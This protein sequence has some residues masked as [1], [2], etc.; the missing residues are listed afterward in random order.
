MHKLATPKWPLLTPLEPHLSLIILQKPMIRE[1]SSQKVSPLLETKRLTCSMISRNTSFF[2]CFI[3][4]G[5][6]PNAP[7]TCTVAFLACCL[8]FSYERTRFLS[9]FLC[10]CCEPTQVKI[11]IQYQSSKQTKLETQHKLALKVL[12]A[13]SAN[14]VCI[15]TNPSRTQ[16]Q[17]ARNNIM[18]ENRDKQWYWC[19]LCKYLTTIDS[20]FIP[21]WK[22]NAFIMQ[23]SVI[24]GYPKSSTSS[25]SSYINTKLFL[26]EDS[27][28]TPPKY[29]LNRLISWTKI[30]TKV[31]VWKRIDW[32]W[33]EVYQQKDRYYFIS[34]TVQTEHAKLCRKV[35]KLCT[36][37]KVLR[38]QGS[39]RIPKY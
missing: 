13:C 4:S 3:P 22:M 2:L 20:D 18:A 6:H 15:P 10:I 19:S 11:P 39:S 29:P 17:T 9:S 25:R 27:L 31:S 26:T 36:D 23:G 8:C 38:T 24:W 35:N 5:R 7:V 33:I 37:L 1:N 28:R 32:Y 30:Y 12:V 14:R 34:S 21:F 16:R